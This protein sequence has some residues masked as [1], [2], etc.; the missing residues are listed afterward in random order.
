[1]ASSTWLE[2]DYTL[3]GDKL[4]IDNFSVSKGSFEVQAYDSQGAYCTF[5]V[6]VT[7]TNIGILALILLLGGGLLVL[8]AILFKL[9]WDYGRS[10]MGNITAENI[11]S[12]QS[13]SMPKSR[14][15]LKLRM[16][17]IGQTGLHPGCYFQATGKNYIWFISKKPVYSDYAAGKTKKIRLESGMDV[18]ICTDQDL[19]HGV[20]VRFDSFVRS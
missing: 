7:S 12:G 10:F 20:I 1:M 17:Q 3:E 2:D 6:K 9:W 15:R 8:L 5:N 16:F 18:R 11:E 14:G 4:T 13:N 19:T